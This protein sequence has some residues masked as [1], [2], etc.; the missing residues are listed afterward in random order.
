MIHCYTNKL[1]PAN[2]ETIGEASQNKAENHN[3]A[4]LLAPFYYSQEKYPSKRPTSLLIW[5][6]NCSKLRPVDRAFKSKL[7]IIIK[8]SAK[9]GI[10]P[11]SRK[12]LQSEEYRYLYEIIFRKM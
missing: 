4:L 7:K 5:L 2:I 8:Y 1:Q 12:R 11:L 3:S 6:D 9:M 10:K